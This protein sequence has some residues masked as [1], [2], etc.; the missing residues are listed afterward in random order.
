MSRNGRHYAKTLLEAPQA[1]LTGPRPVE[2]TDVWVEYPKQNEVIGKPTYT[3]Q[4]AAVPEAMRVDVC[5]DQG[6]WQPCR[7][8][9]G[10]WWF[11]WAD[12]DA[13]EHEVVARIHKDKVG[14]VR[15]EP[16]EFFVR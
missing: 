3:I 7:E 2:Q 14:I 6:D 16:R 15:C 10:L 5:I 1:C 9:L 13:G 8:S 4:V 11:D 12:Y